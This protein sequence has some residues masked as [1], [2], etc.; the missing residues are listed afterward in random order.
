[1]QIGNSGGSRHKGDTKV[2]LSIEKNNLR[3]LILIKSAKP[4]L[5]E[6]K[7]FKRKLLKWRARLNQENIRTI[8]AYPFNPF[9]PVESRHFA[10][11]KYFEQG[12]ELL[13]GIEYWDF[14]GARNTYDELI[15]I[16]EELGD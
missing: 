9:Y 3:Y 7:S 15:E 10:S 5:G 14:I 16:F 8:L 1:M 13:I 11:K 2:K 6:L 4:N 12:N